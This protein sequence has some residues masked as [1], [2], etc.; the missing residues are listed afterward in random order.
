[1]HESALKELCLKLG[2]EPVAFDA[3]SRD[4]KPVYHTNVLMAVGSE[5]VMASAEMIR[6]DKERR[7]FMDTVAASGKELIQLTE[8]Q[9][10]HFAGNT[11]ELEVNGRKLLAISATAY[12]AL[13]AEQLQ[14]LEQWVTLVP[15]NVP[16]IELGGGSIRCM[17][18]Q[19]F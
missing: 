15:I 9:I 12:N 11:L 7:R 17:L 2:Y 13:S 5:F 6:D 4:G 18:A 10:E 3:T 8:D 14:K 1:M 16:T 19:I